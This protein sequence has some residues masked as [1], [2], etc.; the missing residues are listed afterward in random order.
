MM[1]SKMIVF[2]TYAE[3]EM[4]TQLTDIEAQAQFESGVRFTA[5]RIGNWIYD[6]ILKQQGYNPWRY[7]WYGS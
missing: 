7:Y 4:W 3:G 2:V 1:D 5:I 6:F